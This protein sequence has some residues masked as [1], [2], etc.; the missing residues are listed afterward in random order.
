MVSSLAG[1]SR[2]GVHDSTGA[3]PRTTSGVIGPTA[4]ASRLA[5]PARPS[6]ASVV[7][8]AV[9]PAGFR[10]AR[11]QHAAFEHVLAVEMRALAIGR[12]GRMHDGGGAG[13]VQPMQI[14]HRR[15]EGEEGIERQPGRCALQGERLVAAQPIQSGSPT[16]ATAASPS[17]APRSTMV[18]S[19]GSRPSAR[20]SLGANAQANSVPEASQQFAAAR[21]MQCRCTK[22]EGHGVTCV[23]I[24]AP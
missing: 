19:R 11:P 17:S 5:E 12:R 24:R 21:R 23:G 9:E 16:G 8:G 20:A 7:E 15:V 2:G 1:G 4:K 14:G 18:S 10:G 13:S 3:A 6:G 22:I